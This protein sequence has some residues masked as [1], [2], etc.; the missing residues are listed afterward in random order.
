MPLPRIVVEKT[1]GAAKKAIAAGLDEFNRRRL[2][3]LRAAG[4][5]VTLRDGETIVGGIIADIMG[6]WAIVNL[7]WIDEKFR[8]VGHGRA[9]L[10]AAEAEAKIRGAKKA[11]VDTFSFQAPEFYLREG[12]KAYGIVEDFPIAGESWMRLKKA[13]K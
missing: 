5:A 8:R 12:Y 2:G 3:T 7:L 6:D 13:L 1:Y 10:H 9:L 11:L 4:F